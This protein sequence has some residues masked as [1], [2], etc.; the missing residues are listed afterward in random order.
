MKVDYRN[1]C[2]YRINVDGTSEEDRL[3]GFQI[4]SRMFFNMYVLSMK[5]VSAYVK[6]QMNVTEAKECKV[7]NPDSKIFLCLEQPIHTNAGVSGE[8]ILPILDVKDP[9][10]NSN[11]LMLV[12]NNSM[13]YMTMPLK[14]ADIASLLSRKRAIVAHV[15]P[16]IKD[17]DIF[18]N[19][20]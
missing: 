8:I 5:N 13:E 3:E 14:H 10:D 12:G 15:D 6:I 9:M 1:K 4:E 19:L 11:P 18:Y 7:Q 16:E 2:A 20:D 17:E